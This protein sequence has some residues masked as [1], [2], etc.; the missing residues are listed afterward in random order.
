MNEYK[1]KLYFL[2]FVWMV[3]Q[4]TKYLL[5][6]FETKFSKELNE[7]SFCFSLC[8][9]KALDPI[10]RNV[11]YL[12]S[13]L[14]ANNIEIIIIY[15]VISFQAKQNTITATEIG[16]PLSRFQLISSPKT[17]NWKKSTEKWIQSLKTNRWTLNN[18]VEKV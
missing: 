6:K 1:N 7:D 16:F 9:I 15:S 5:P 3:N 12:F 4:S 17:Q 8:P 10:R 13:F 11:I 14:V 2:V 18:N